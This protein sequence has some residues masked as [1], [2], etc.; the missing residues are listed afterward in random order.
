MLTSH[1]E[2][3]S[4]QWLDQVMQNWIKLQINMSEA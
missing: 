1:D 4:A 3:P 2:C